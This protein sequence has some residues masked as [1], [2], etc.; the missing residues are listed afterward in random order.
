MLTFYTRS[1]Y[2]GDWKAMKIEKLKPRH[3]HTHP[4]DTSTNILPKR[5]LIYRGFLHV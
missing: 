5:I 2:G 3:P 4:W 1:K